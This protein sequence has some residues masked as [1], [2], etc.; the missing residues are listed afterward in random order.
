MLKV[1]DYRLGKKKLYPCRLEISFKIQYTASA[2]TNRNGLMKNQVT[3]VITES[4][5]SS[6]K[7]SL[8]GNDSG[9]V[10]YGPI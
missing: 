9:K 1:N 7:K 2:W 3:C 6:N 4:L 5:V 8:L 10:Y